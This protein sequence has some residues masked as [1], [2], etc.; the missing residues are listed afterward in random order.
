MVGNFVSNYG[1]EPGDWGLGG[2]TVFLPTCDHCDST[3]TCVL[4]SVSCSGKQIVTALAG[5]DYCGK[6]TTAWAS[7]KLSE[8]NEKMTFW[9]LNSFNTNKENTCIFSP[10]V[11]KNTQTRREL[12]TMWGWASSHRSWGKIYVPFLDSAAS[13]FT[14]CCVLIP[15][16]DLESLPEMRVEQRPCHFHSQTH[17]W[18]LYFH[19]FTPWAPF[20]TE[21]LH[22]LVSE[23]RVTAPLAGQDGTMQ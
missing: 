15:V 4:C 1:G 20:Q 19:S 18:V 9:P 10:S 12:T 13:L 16:T 23:C 8:V 5:T 11:W 14:P 7:R 2:R 6:N 17:A 3:E 21:A 22:N